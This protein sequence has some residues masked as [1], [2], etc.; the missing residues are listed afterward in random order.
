LEILCLL[1]ENPSDDSV[2]LAIKLIKE[3]GQKL[4]QL[5]PRILDFI[6]TRLRF[7]LRETSLDKRTLNMIEVLCAIRIDAFKAN[8]LIPSDLDLVHG[9]DQYTHTI[10]LTDPCEPEPMLGMR[11][12]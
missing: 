3:C 11:K 7:L 6:F 8:P 12:I 4:S 9:D 10:S 1:F 2:E 5:C